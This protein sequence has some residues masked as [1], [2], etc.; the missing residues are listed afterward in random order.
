MAQLIVRKLE[1]EIVAKLK[2]RAGRRGRSA[3]EEH[4]AI[5]RKVLLEAE[6]EHSEMTFEEYLRQMPDVGDDEDFARI[7]GV[8]R[9]IDF[10]E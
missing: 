7:E 10:S 4:R 2:E 3:E 1:P 8:M 9:D 5:L 6:E